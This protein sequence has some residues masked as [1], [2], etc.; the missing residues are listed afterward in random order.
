[1][2]SHCPKKNKVVLALSTM[3]HD[4]AIDED[5]GEQRKP[6]LITDYNRTKFG[7][8]LVDQ[9]CTQYDMSRN[10]RRWPLTVF[11]D[12]LNIS[13]V[14]A[15]GIYKLNNVS[16]KITRRNF[17]QEVAFPLI[18][19]VMFKRFQNPHISPQIKQRIG[20][21]LKI[22]NQVPEE[23]ENR[24]STTG[25][26]HLCGRARNKTTRKSCSNCNR[27]TCPAHLKLICMNCADKQQHSF[28]SNED[29]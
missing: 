17:L 6:E 27:W 18:K 28:I 7:V 11:F 24:N 20:F 26:C 3:H 9:L 1:M 2:I 13:A 22:S 8:D 23:I 19:P 21:L 16:T 15:Y 10:S 14:N 29:C 12:L 25:R 5:T 4:M